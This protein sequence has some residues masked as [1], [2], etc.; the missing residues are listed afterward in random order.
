MYITKW[1][2][3]SLIG[4]FCFCV[5]HFFVQTKEMCSGTLVACWTTSSVKELRAGTG[6]NVLFLLAIRMTG[7]YC[8]Q[9]TNLKYPEISLNFRGS[10]RPTTRMKLAN[11]FTEINHKFCKRQ[12]Q[13]E[14]PNIESLH[15]F[16]VVTSGSS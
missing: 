7:F 9:L 14:F 12:C 6:W 13:I 15:G 3:Q 5:K 11:F 8:R 1:S 10:K 2:T 16:K 4:S